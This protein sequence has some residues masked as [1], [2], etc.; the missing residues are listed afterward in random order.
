MKHLIKTKGITITLIIILGLIFASCNSQHAKKRFSKISWQ[1]SRKPIRP[2]KP[3][4]VPFWNKYSKR[5]IYAPAFDYSTV[6]GASQY[7]Y[8]ILSLSD[9]SRYQF[10]S[11]MP[12]APLSP[13]WTK[14]PVGYFKL[15]VIG[16]SGQGDHLGLAGKG[17]YYRASP[18]DPPSDGVY[19]EAVIPYDSSAKLALATLMHE[20][21]VNHWLTHKSPDPEFK[22]Y[23]Y[24]AK[25][26]GALITGAVM[27]ANL[28]PD[29]DEARRAQKIAVIVANYLLSIS[30]SK[31]SPLAYFPPTYYG[32]KAILSKPGHMESDHMMISYGVN[33]GQGYLDLYNLTGQ[34][35]Y[36]VAAK[37][38]ARTYLN[39]QHDN[40]TW[41]LFVNTK[42]GKPLAE[43]LIIPIRIINY[44]TRLQTEYH[45][46]GLQ[47]P[48]EA[49]VSWI[50]DH[51]VKTFNWQAQYE[52][53]GPTPPYKDLT[54][55]EACDFAVYLFKHKKH[56]KLAKELT[57]FSEDQFVIW[58]QPRPMNLTGGHAPGYN[59][60]NWITPSA[61][62]QYAYWAP[63]MQSVAEVLH[64]YWAGYKVTGEKI[65][66]AKAKSLANSITLAQQVYD[67]NYPTLLTKEKYFPNTGNWINVTVN[68]VKIMLKFGKY[69]KN[70]S[71]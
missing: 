38:I 48:I 23:R 24:P 28:T 60:T 3:G 45:M 27:Y 36:L 17:K 49:A 68:S 46:S 21:Y 33:T 42:T 12:Y 56:L 69:L 1:K 52:D 44:L 35:K 22:L 19:H 55:E 58:E 62:E 43:N 10:E 47:K 30:E 63:V 37:R 14:I 34:K 71:N 59:T 40:G 20:S 66:L 54:R 6:K 51:P 13:V 2:G 29:V 4:K 26:M 11:S 64:A 50:M 25:I 8:E 9:S 16:V 57:R 5:F 31:G 7:R 61:Q 67:G 18:Y 32:Y 39:R 53:V 41:Y 65:Y 70:N 15:K